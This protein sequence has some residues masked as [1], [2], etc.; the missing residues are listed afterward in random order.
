MTTRTYTDEL[1]PDDYCAGRDCRA[2]SNPDGNC[3][4][5]C[6]APDE[7]GD[8]AACRYC[9]ELWS[10]DMLRDDKRLPQHTFG[11]FLA[12]CAGSGEFPIA[13]T[14]EQVRQWKSQQ[15]EAN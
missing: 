2:C 9:G 3:T 5:Q 1:P 10:N 12:Q 8:Y 13:P 7:S 4:C 14:A 15:S 11:N 6:H